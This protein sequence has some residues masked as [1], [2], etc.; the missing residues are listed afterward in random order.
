MLIENVVNASDISGEAGGGLVSVSPQTT[1]LDV[2][3]VLSDSNIGV[4]MVLE[5]D[6]ILVGVLT[7]RDIIAA[8]AKHGDNA[9]QETAETTM[10]QD[11]KTC[12][13]RDN[14]KDV[15]NTMSKGRFRHMPILSGNHLTGLVSA[16]DILMFYMKYANLNDRQVILAIIL[17]S[18]LVYPGG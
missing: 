12:S 15:I 10:T 8:I 6:D 14:P 16:T 2:S 11:V 5:D 17:E 3:R 9:L 1:L 13:P 18:G 4:V 7:E